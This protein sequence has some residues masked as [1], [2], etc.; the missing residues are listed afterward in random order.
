MLRANKLQKRIQTLNTLLDEIQV[1]R[2]QSENGKKSAQGIFRT[3][4]H[5]KHQNSEYER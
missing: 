1:N 5:G 4:S 2:Q 3:R